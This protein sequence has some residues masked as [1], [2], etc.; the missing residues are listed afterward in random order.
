MLA[1][2]FNALSFYQFNKGKL[3]GNMRKAVIV[4]ILRENWR[5]T[6]GRVGWK[7]EKLLAK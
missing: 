7:Y 5:A 4:V 6:Q 3:E 2:V 1:N